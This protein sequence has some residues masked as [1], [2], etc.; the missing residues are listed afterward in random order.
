M[1]VRE[2]TLVM[3]SVTASGRAAGTAAIL[4]LATAPLATGSLAARC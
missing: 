2:D 1:D 4:F 3:R